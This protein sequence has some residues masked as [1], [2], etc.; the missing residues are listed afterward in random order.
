MKFAN[1]KQKI[2]Y[3]LDKIG[4]ELQLG[5]DRWKRMKS[6]YNGVSQCIENDPDFFKGV[7]FDI[8]P[9]GSVRI[10]T[11]TKPI[12]NQEYDL[13]VVLQL[14][15]DWSNEK[16]SPFTVYNE[17][18]RVL[19]NNEVYKEKLETKN[20]V[21]RLNYAGDFHMDIM[22]GCQEDIEDGNKIRIPDKEKRHWKSSNPKGYANWFD[23]T[24]K[25]YEPTLLTEL[26]AKSE[27]L[28]IETNYEA[29]PP[30]KRAV[31]LIKRYRDIYYKDD[32][33]FKVS[34]IILTTIAGLFYEGNNSIVDTIRSIV[35]NLNQR[36]VEFPNAPF[37]ITNPV[38]KDENFADKWKDDVRYYNS[39]KKFIKDFKETWDEV[40]NYQDLDESKNAFSELF[41]EDY[42]NRVFSLTEK[43][44]NSDLTISEAKDINTAFI[45]GSLSVSGSKSEKTIS[46]KERGGFHGKEEI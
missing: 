38:N 5:K 24:S 3:I 19:E 30:L 20:R 45:G 40:E 26:F 29:I 27:D 17:L 36:F 1:K 28:P 39:F 6:A 46:V 31:Q 12:K 18:K 34:S 8:Y 14:N 11:T 7:Q 21:I 4:Q 37:E 25:I 42:V 10:G 22:P 23:K 13:D 16:Y 2:E 44:E 32:D 15:L 33:E 35:N 41:G 9:H 43:Y